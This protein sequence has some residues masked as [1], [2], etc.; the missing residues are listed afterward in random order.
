MAPRR[1]GSIAEAEAAA[2]AL[3]REFRIRRSPVPVD[4][5]AHR[6]GVTISYEPFDGNVSGMLYRKDQRVII[7][8]NARQA[9]TRQR[10]TVAHELGHL[11]LHPGDKVFIDP[12]VRVNFRDDL[13]SQGTDIEEIQANAFAAALLMPKE[14]VRREV[15]RL[16]GQGW[17][18]EDA[19]LD[20]L[21]KHF[22][23]ST[24]ATQHRLMNLGLHRQL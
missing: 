6:L 13:A 9:E 24:Q 16:A 8:V 1:P 14:W 22:A 12:M 4:S 19:L 5:I 3:R 15:D 7:G 23:V 10:F 17:P 20:G 21:A 18:G 11:R 2:D